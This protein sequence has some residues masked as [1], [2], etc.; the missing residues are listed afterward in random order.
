[1]EKK[2]IMEDQIGSSWPWGTYYLED[3]IYGLGGG[4]IMRPEEGRNPV[5][6]LSLVGPS[7][8]T[9]LNSRELYRTD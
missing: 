1:L 9:V 8:P 6:A 4:C 2:K 7:H 3:A 5:E